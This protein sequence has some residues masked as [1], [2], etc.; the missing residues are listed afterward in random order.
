LGLATQ[1]TVGYGL[2]G[3]GYDTN[4][5]TQPVVYPSVMDQLFNQSLIPAKAYSMYLD[6]L[7]SASG[8]IIFGGAD[9]GK[10]M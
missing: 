3:I 5:A 4:E 1:T 7:T 2:M 10:F 8:T 9:T 6:D